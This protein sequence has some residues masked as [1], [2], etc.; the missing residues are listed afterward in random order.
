MIYGNI[1][2]KIEIFEYSVDVVQNINFPYKYVIK[3]PLELW[4]RDIFPF[5]S[6]GVEL[7]KYIAYVLVIS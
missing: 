5:T 3:K 1:N 7:L 6:G 4:S 2:I